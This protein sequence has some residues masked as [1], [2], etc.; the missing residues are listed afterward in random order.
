MAVSK[1]INSTIEELKSL[2]L[3]IVTVEE[4][5]LVINKLGDVAL[6]GIEVTPGGMILRGRPNQEEEYYYYEEDISYISDE[7]IS[8]ARWSLSE[9]ETSTVNRGLKGR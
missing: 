5:K 4:I 7:S 1:N 3:R 2:D 8:P 9:A 6:F